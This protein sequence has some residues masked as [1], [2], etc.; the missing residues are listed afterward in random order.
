MARTASRSP[1]LVRTGV[2]VVPGAHWPRWR[3][4][5][6]RQ[7]AGSAARI[8][9]LGHAVAGPIGLAVALL[10]AGQVGWTGDPVLAGAL[11]GLVA[12][13]H[14][15][16]RCPHE[17]V[18]WVALVVACAGLAFGSALSLVTGHRAVIL[19]AL[20]P[21]DAGVFIFATGAAVANLAWPEIRDDGRRLISTLVDTAILAMVVV[22][23]A[24]HVLATAGATVQQ[25]ALPALV[26]SGE[27]LLPAITAMLAL[28]QISERRRPVGR[29]LLVGTTTFLIGSVLVAGG[30]AADLSLSG[31]GRTLQLGA[32]GLL[33]LA[34]AVGVH[35]A[36]QTQAV[37]TRSAAPPF[38]LPAMAGVTVL[39]FF[40]VSAWSGKG[41]CSVGLLLLGGG[42]LAREVLVAVA[43][44]RTAGQLQ[45]SA[46]FEARLLAVQAQVTP[47]L[48]N[49]E[50]LRRWCAL[51]AETL[52]ADAVLAWIADGDALVLQAVAP[53]R[54]E[55]LVG[56]QLP[57]R[58][59]SALAVRA[60]RS[61]SAIAI[62]GT[63]S[64]APDERFLF[65]VLDARW[66]LGVSI[67]SQGSPI[68]ALVL[69]RE[70]NQSPFSRFEIQKARLLAGHIAAARQRLE[71]YGEL[72]S[73]QR[74]VRLVH[75]FAQWAPTAKSANDIAWQ[76][77]QAIRS[78]FPFDH[79]TVFLGDG[80]S[81]ASERPIARFGE[82]RLPTDAARISWCTAPLQ[83]AEVVLG[84]VEV[85]RFD[86]SPFSAGEQR[87]IT[88][89]A[90]QAA[91]AIQNQRLQEES[92]KA[93][94]YRELN[95]QKTERLNA[96]SHDLRGPL[97]N[98]KAY[99]ETLSESGD[100]LA[101][102]ERASFL[103]TIREEADR[104]RDLLDG[105]L[106]LSRLEAGVLTMERE[107]LLLRH[108]AERAIAS[109]PT[110]EHRIDVEVPDDLFILGDRRRIGQVLH[111]LIENA[112]KY[113]PQGGAIRIAAT[114]TDDEVF[115]SVSDQGVGIPRHQWN[116]IFEPYHRAETVG[117]IS[118]TGLGL[119][120]CKGIVE[121]HSGRIWVESAVGV[122]S[123]FSFTLPVAHVTEPHRAADRA[124]RRNRP[125]ESER[126]PPA[127]R[128][129]NGQHEGNLHR[130]R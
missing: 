17:R 73:H 39:I 44:H 109:F 119:A 51:A 126:T 26:G 23:V 61:P 124:S 1:V 21:A 104:L 22:V 64:N 81:S 75:R 98:I 77:L 112:I 79:G 58:E 94:I 19:G 33:V 129:G 101:E 120:I 89:L 96:I 16:A 93:A 76:L 57:L 14:A 43:R 28:P 53:A 63:A 113:S 55:S 45:A 102:E 125:A 9:A 30:A 84:T 128:S 46:D 103:A 54:R 13:A 92:G 5:A 97:A 2:R 48:S 40:S 38:T 115:I 130:D 29:L 86:G 20:T 3:S 34:A 10:L 88:A 110:A 90:Q 69:V 82:R 67:R 59:Q 117:Q 18:P 85:A 78:Q 127:A 32:F 118:G 41:A 50:S 11:A 6:F 52:R 121:A 37:E 66:C 111:N 91:I 60:F 99:A 35:L 36:P 105:L 107:P 100:E 116:K 49:R 123:T 114:R 68:G 24:A 72:E 4:P 47:Q 25:T 65:T 83:C 70:P 12:Y 95:K 62:R 106:D 108:L 27:L 42:L 122:G 71:L 87:T 7:L 15:M 31:A 8:Q 74:E 80:A 56:R